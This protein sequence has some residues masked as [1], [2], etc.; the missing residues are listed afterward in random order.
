ML[1]ATVVVAIEFEKYISTFES[2]LGKYDSIVGAQISQGSALRG[3]HVASHGG[4][5]EP[6]DL[7]E[8]ES[9]RTVFLDWPVLQCNALYDWESA[10][11]TT[12][13]AA[14]RPGSVVCAIQH[15]RDRE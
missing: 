13:D 6:N 1:H 4:R 3:S 10:D 14:R 7:L 5:T 9:R 12:N 2:L 15:S 11:S 8:A